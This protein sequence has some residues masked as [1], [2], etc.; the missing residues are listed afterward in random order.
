MARAGSSRAA[1]SFEYEGP[2]VT[3]GMRWVGLNA[4]R[5]LGSTRGDVMT[6][7]MGLDQYRA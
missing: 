7:V 2:T 3:H 6:I 5:A 1:R 4:A